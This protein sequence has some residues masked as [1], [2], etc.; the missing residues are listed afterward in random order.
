MYG[1]QYA[2]ASLQFTLINEILIRNG[3]SV[4]LAFYF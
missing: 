3:T 2:I 4:L 1:E